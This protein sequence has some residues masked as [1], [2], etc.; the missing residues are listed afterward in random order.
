VSTPAQLSA[1]GYLEFELG[2]LTVPGP[3]RR[4]SLPGTAKLAFDE[5][6]GVRVGGE[7]W[8]RNGA[9]GGAYRAGPGDTAVVLK[10]RLALT[11]E[12]ALG[13]ELGRSLP[14]GQSGIGAG[15]GAATFTAIYSRDFGR[16][17]VDLN[18]STSRTDS[19]DPG[20][21]LVATGWAAALSRALG[22]RWQA[23][24]EFSGTRQGGV[25]GTGQMLF[26]LS[27]SVSRSLVFDAGFARN[28]RGGIYSP[29]LFTGF[30]MLGPPLF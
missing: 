20:I 23:A 22:S 26:A 16:S 15:S 11:D 6:W 30:T 4:D 3:R 17:H 21:G 7:G 8:V 9:T 27:Y 14:T 2:A 10:H 29:T 1:P 18:L 13:W 25:A 5:D 19:A 12:S 24:A 28:V